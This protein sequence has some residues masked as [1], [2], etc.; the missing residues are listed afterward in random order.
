MSTVTFYLKI[1]D[2]ENL[3]IDNHSTERNSG[4]IS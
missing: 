1:R 2:I 4:I 3:C